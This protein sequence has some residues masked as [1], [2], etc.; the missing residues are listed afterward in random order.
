MFRKSS[1]EKSPRDGFLKA[2]TR[3]IAHEVQKVSHDT[4]PQDDESMRV[5]VALLKKIEILQQLQT[6]LTGLIDDPESD[7]GTPI[8][9]A[10]QRFEK[11]VTG[12]KHS[13]SYL[14]I[15]NRMPKVTVMKQ[16]LLQH[17]FI[18]DSHT[19]KSSVSLDNERSVQH[20]DAPSVPH[21]IHDAI[22]LRS[23]PLPLAV[24][25]IANLHVPTG[26]PPSL[27]ALSVTAKPPQQTGTIASVIEPSNKPAHALQSPV[28]DNHAA[29]SAAPQIA[30]VVGLSQAIAETTMMPPQRVSAHTSSFPTSSLSAVFPMTV[31]DM[32]RETG[33]A[34]TVA[35]VGRSQQEM[36]IQRKI[37]GAIEAL[38]R[39]TNRLEKEIKNRYFSFLNR[40]FPL[41]QKKIRAL[42][43]L[44]TLLQTLHYPS[45]GTVDQIDQLNTVVQQHVKE[46][47]VLLKS[48]FS[49]R[50]RNLLTNI[51]AYQP[52]K[53]ASDP[54]GL[55]M[56]PMEGARTRRFV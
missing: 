33:T 5:S 24:P 28:T 32:V 2:L 13:N 44:A 30:P 52:E 1:Q 53:G 36:V 19:P 43:T 11:E 50:T 25:S 40:L 38:N 17:S 14:L 12:Y 7:W 29:R 34:A 45:V 4:S 21:T 27:D 10:L 56:V 49:H 6:Q 9:A 8:R 41:K 55:D 22:H 26:R 20:A 46:N 31:D 3:R 47:P 37:Q 23:K 39:F 48:R 54:F 35:H 15:L 16:D 51:I 42:C 18:G